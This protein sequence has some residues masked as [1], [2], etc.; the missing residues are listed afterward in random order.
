M[1]PSKPLLVLQ[2]F[3]LHLHTNLSLR[4]ALTLKRI[5][6]SHR[7]HVFSIARRPWSP[8]KQSITTSSVSS[9]KR[10]ARSSPWRDMME[11]RFFRKALSTTACLTKLLTLFIMAC[12]VY[13][14]EPKYRTPELFLNF[15]RQYNKVS[16]FQ[17]DKTSHLSEQP[18]QP[19]S[20]EQALT[21]FFLT[22][23]EVITLK[24]GRLSLTFTSNTIL[25]SYISC[26]QIT[27]L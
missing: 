5:S 17:N 18:G 25:Q 16:K 7:W 20:Y 24:M 14:T 15:K 12:Q 3:R 27:K 4:P 9:P 23:S 21:N 26:V 19:G 22:E 11:V 13:A 2:P 6:V 1:A 8:F 10:T